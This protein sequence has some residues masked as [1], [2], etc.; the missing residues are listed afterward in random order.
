MNVLTVKTMVHGKARDVQTSLF[1][2]SKQKIQ[3]LVD[4]MYLRTGIMNWTRRLDSW[5]ELET[6][7]KQ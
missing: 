5:T 4:I 6:V 2:I 7:F 3:A 1:S